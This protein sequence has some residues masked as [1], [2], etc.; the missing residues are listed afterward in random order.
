MVVRRIAVSKELT[1]YTRIKCHL[2][3]RR[4]SDFLA[5]PPLFPSSLSILTT[6]GC[7]PISSIIVRHIPRPLI[8]SRIFPGQSYARETLTCL[9]LQLQRLDLTC[10]L[11]GS[12]ACR[13]RATCI[14]ESGSRR[15]TNI[16]SRR[17]TLKRSHFTVSAASGCL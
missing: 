1:R 11:N 14:A 15:R 5:S 12:I 3:S 16:S 10:R 2:L 8:S 13:H 7:T 17:S 4:S 6:H 9:E